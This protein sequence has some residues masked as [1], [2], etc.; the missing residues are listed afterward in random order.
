MGEPRKP[1]ARSSL[2]RRRIRSLPSAKWIE[3]MFESFIDSIDV[4]VFVL[5]TAGIINRVNRFITGQYRWKPA[6][7]IGKNIFELMPDL[8]D[9]G[10]EERFREIIRVR[11]TRELTNVERLSRGGDRVVFNLK[12]IPIVEG[13]EVKGVLAVMNDIT[14]KRAL[15]SQVAETEQYL[16]SLIDNANDIIYTLD[17]DGHITILNKMGQAITG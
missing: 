6:E 17:R 1:R 3:A 13:N 12:G 15:Q 4:G 5:D 7:L 16:Q 8:R 2:C 10:V 14:E 11:R 9:L